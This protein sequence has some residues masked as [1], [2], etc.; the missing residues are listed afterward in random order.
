MATYAKADIYPSGS[1]FTGAPLLAPDELHRNQGELSWNDLEAMLTGFAYDAYCNKSY[2]AE[3]NYFTV[4]DYAIDQGFAY[5]SG[6]GT[7]HHYGYQIRKIYTTA[8]LMRKAILKSSRR[9]D[10]LKTLLFGLLCRKRDVLAPRY[11]MKCSTPGT[12]CCSPS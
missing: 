6:M 3:S 9:D 2:E 8:W 10:I 4:W 11:A 5:G 12:P 1:G 7:N